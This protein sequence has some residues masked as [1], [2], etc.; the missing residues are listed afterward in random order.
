MIAVTVSGDRRGAK[1]R[2]PNQ[3]VL[4]HTRFRVICRTAK[5]IGSTS[6]SPD[7]SQVE[8]NK[9]CHIVAK[10]QNFGP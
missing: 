1:Q 2:S 4:K 5:A 7:V 8:E 10:C 6:L 9:S 3:P